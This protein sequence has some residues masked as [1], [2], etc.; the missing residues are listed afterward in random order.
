M[1]STFSEDYRKKALGQIPL[2]RFGKAEEVAEVVYFLL[3]E[4]VSYITGQVIQ[5]DGGLGI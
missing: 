5:I 1:T 3:N 4:K 2:G